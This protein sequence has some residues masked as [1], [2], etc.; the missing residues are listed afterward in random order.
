M[1][2]YGTPADSCTLGARAELI[3][4]DSSMVVEGEPRKRR[5]PPKAPCRDW[6]VRI[7]TLSVVS[8]TAVGG[9]RLL[10]GSAL[11]CECCSAHSIEPRR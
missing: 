9:R 10:L 1:E 8:V 7:A 5:S 4:L 2:P 11:G 3:S 6:A